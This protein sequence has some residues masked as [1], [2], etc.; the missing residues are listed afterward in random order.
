MFDHF[1][2][3]VVVV[4]P[5]IVLLALLLS[6]RLAPG[7]AA[8]TLAWSAAGA[9]VAA[10]VNLALFAVKAVAELPAIAGL[11]GWS[12]DVVA[13]DTAQV[14]WVSWLSLGWLVLALAAVSRHRL[15]RRR[16]LRFVA[17]LA[18]PPAGQQV[19][20]VADPAVDAYS[21]PGSPGRIVVTSGMR[22]LLD[23]ERYAAML[24]HE[25]AHLT[26]RHHRL[27]ELAQ[28]AGAVHPA[29]WWVAGQVDYL[30]ERAA[31]EHA[32]AAVGSRR[33]VA[34]AIGVAAVARGGGRPVADGL[35]IAVRPG[36][37]PRRVAALLRPRARRIP[38]WMRLLPA[39]LALSSL[40]WTGEAAYDLLELLHAARLSRP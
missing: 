17:A 32:A 28:L 5:L 23:D 7:P 40:V 35:H 37:V 19:V 21:I 33:V 24:A 27:V 20:V 18:R 30:V 9:A 6:D 36:V 13:R 38:A 2:W 34:H 15:A 26:G 29:L 11:L 39:T 4:P 1:A 14:P 8:V 31:D 16:A 22:D 25:R 12:H 3:S 10:L